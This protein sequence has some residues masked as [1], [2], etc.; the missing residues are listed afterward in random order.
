[1]EALLGCDHCGSVI[2][3]VRADGQRVCAQCGHP[4]RT[5]NLLEA[6]ELDRERR[7]ADR[8]RMETRVNSRAG[9]DYRPGVI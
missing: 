7:T 4:L 1:M 6:R 9:T 5:V 2:R 3:G 8:Y